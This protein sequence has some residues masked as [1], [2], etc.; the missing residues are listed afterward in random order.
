VFE[1]PERP[2]DEI[3]LLIEKAFGFRPLVLVLSKEELLKAV[4]QCPYQSDLGKT[5]HY[6]FLEKT[7][8]T[9]RLELLDAVKKDSE[10]YSLTDRVFYLQ[11]PEGIGK[12]KLIE[13]SDRALPGTQ[14]TAR[15]HNAIDKPVEMVS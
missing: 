14:M 13:K 7:P 1:H 12:S 3:E 2:K 6:F 4:K 5:I 10:N 11:A 8:Q 9:T 15:D